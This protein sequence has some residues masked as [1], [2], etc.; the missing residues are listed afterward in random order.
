MTKQEIGDRIASASLVECINVE[1]DGRFETR[2]YKMGD[3]Y[4]SIAFYNF[5]PRANKTKVSSGEYK[6]KEVMRK[7]RMVEEVYYE[8]V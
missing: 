1:D 7:S 5:A 8:E 3:K 4:Y 6:V 2:I